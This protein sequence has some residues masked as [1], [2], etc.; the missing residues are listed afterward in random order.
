MR[1]DHILITGGAGFVGSNLAV[2]FRRAFSSS[3]ITC[4]DNLRR[5]GSELTLARLKEHGIDFVHGDIRCLEDFEILPDFD[6]LI[7]CSAE[8]S[9][10]AGVQSSA[11]GVFNI[12]N[13]GTF[14]CLEV[15]RLRNAAF[16][17]L[18]SSRVYPIELINSLNYTEQPTRFEL[19]AEQ[20]IQGSSASGISELFP[21]HGPRSLY[22]ATK[23]SGELFIQEYCYNFGLKAII[24][25][26]GII[27]G[28]WQMGKVDQG[29][30][31]LWVAKHYFKDKLHYIGF[32]GNGKQVR[33][34]VHIDDLSNLLL[35]QLESAESW[36]GDVFN[37]GGGAEISFSLLELSQM[38]QQVTGNK[39][40]ILP[41]PTT[42]QLDLRI[43]TT[44]TAK[45]GD[46][47]GWSP[48]KQVPRIVEDIHKWL[49]ENETVL[50]KVFTG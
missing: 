30:V 19:T 15:A 16:V 5:R 26:C 42:N 3:K 44:D 41:L 2:Y 46:I 13:V 32:G 17:Y 8:P 27:A 20:T 45:V 1:F 40:D 29:V 49:V 37:V 18:S 25:R 12:N 48:E 47:Y 36:H 22:G 10:T 43:Y 39:L 50:R 38:C 23:L 7:D 28:P 31:A 35:R 4:F 33:D 24:N 14:N 21:L 6:L 9:V 34:V 11:L